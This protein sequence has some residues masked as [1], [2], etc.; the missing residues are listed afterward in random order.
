MS[1]P[2]MAV[3]CHSSGS[4]H[5]SGATATRGLAGQRATAT[6]L[7][8]GAVPAVPEPGGFALFALGALV[9]RRALQSRPRSAGA[10]G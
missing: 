3:D 8:E 1:L 7:A 5:D 2:M 4:P 6:G 9:A 10:R